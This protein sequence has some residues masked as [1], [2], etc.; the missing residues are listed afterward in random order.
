MT[1]PPRPLPLT[2]AVAAATVALLLAPSAALAVPAAADAPA[3]AWTVETVDG[4]N[5]TARPNFSYAADPG[6]VIADTM[7]VTNTG[8]TPLDL[9]VYA[10]DAFTTPSGNIDLDTAAT[11]ADDAG[12]WVTAA[13]ARLVLAPGQQGDVAF[14]VAVPAD[15]APGD[16]SAGLITS[17][18]GA[19]AGAAID[20][21]RRLGSR[22]TVRVSGEL[23]PSVAVSDVATSYTPSW[24]PF[25]PGTLTLSYRMSNTGNTL[26]AGRDD[27]SASGL[28]GMVGLTVPAVALAEVIPGSTID[29][30][31]EIPVAP[32]GWVSGTITVN[33]EAV[34]LGAQ[35][36]AAV[37]QDYGV[38]AVPWTLLVVLAVLAGAAVA[39][40]LLLRRRRAAAPPMPPVAP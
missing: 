40:W 26:V 18:R 34:G 30:V 17:F 16:H 15:A 37:T 33:P 6:T 10:A 9:A 4:A 5:G 31:R 28:F 21:D 27:S 2:A 24:N 22:I 7:R 36:I 19:D 11:P 3:I 23:A 20:V 35:D 14:T 29:V 38:L 12:A 32:W 1:R 8:T 39:A 25:E 13:P